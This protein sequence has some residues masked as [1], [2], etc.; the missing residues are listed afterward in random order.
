ME[1]LKKLI[2]EINKAF[3]EF[4]STNEIRLKQIESKGHADPLVTEK[5]E[6]ANSEISRLQGEIEAMKT[7]MNRNG[8]DGGTKDAK[9]EKEEK[10]AKYKEAFNG[11]ARKGREL[12]EEFKALSIDDD[13]NGGVLV[14]PE[15][16]SQ[17]VQ[18]VFESSPIRQLASVQ[19]VSSDQLDV[20]QDLDQVGSGWV[21]EET[22]RTS[23]A[24]PTW[25]M[26][27]IPVHELYAEPVASQR[28]LD[29]SMIDLESW[30][31]QKV[32]DK[33][34][35]DEATAFVSGNGINKPR[36][37][38]SYPSGTSYG[39]VEQVG[40]GSS[41]VFTAD[42]LIKISYALK[43]AYQKN[44]SWLMQRASE[45]LVRAL[46]DSQN[47]YLWAPAL[48]AS[49]PSTLLGFP[50]Y[51]AAD[52]ATAAANS[53]SAIFGDIKSSYQ[54]VDRIGIRTLR[55]PY[56]TKGFVTF[57]TTKRVGGDVVNFDSFKILKLG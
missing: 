11:Y 20:L 24:S 54:V 5:M 56:S 23:T 37:L 12:P 1:E 39:Q 2:E 15:M 25:K 43:E 4:K 38:T 7:A 21:G 29:D 46:K 27:K 26:A 33:F 31:A 40:T 14:T 48:D 41:G 28:I 6:K 8:A 17:I 10:S 16:A 51:T 53:L 19:S 34:I 30:L 22:S 55:D 44:A 52:M 9:T 47:R 49:K 32:S 57:Y 45:G 18:F 35:R 3:S 13:S 36:G 42:S 50:I